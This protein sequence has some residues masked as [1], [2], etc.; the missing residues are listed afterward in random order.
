MREKIWRCLPLTVIII[1]TLLRVA[2]YFFNR[3]LTE[4]EAPLALNILGRSYGD[5]LKPLDFVQAAPVGFLWIQ[6]FAVTLLGNHELVFRLVPLVAGTASLVLFYLIGRKLLTREATAIAL[7]IFAINDNLIYFASE[8][9]QYSTDVMFAVIILLAGLWVIG[10]RYRARPLAVF[11][12]LG[13]SAVW[14][15]HPALFVSAS[16][17]GVIGVSMFYDRRSRAVPWLVLAL[18][19]AVA[20]WLANYL[21]VLAV[22]RSDARLLDFWQRS[23]VPLVPRSLSDLGLIARAIAR[24][25]KNPGGFSVYDSLIAAGACGTGLVSL[26]RK[27]TRHAFALL[28]PVLAVYLASGLRLYPFEGRLLL[29]LAP[30]IAIMTA[31]GADTVRAAIAQT[32]RTGSIAVVALVLA[33]PAGAALF[34]LAKPRAPEELRPVLA[35]LQLR[36]SPDQALYVYYAAANAFKYYGPRYGFGPDEFIPGVEAR[37]DWTGYYEDL[38]KLARTGHKKAW[39]VMSHILKGHGVDEERLFRSHLE[40]LGDITDVI[41][42]SG[43]AAY[44]CEFETIDEGRRDN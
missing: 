23:F 3:S 25:F 26:F 5:L 17:F 2:Q 1:G 9:K 41:P 20:G 18:L 4:G 36:K 31:A 33:Y 37:D 24:I 10:G 13:G 12:L 38:K 19:V 16:L 15:S 30:F 43:A 42:G 11:G 6:K 35:E 21:L 29:F 44:L 32:S 7:I 39:I 14:F 34:H 28:L 40:M 27:K 8:L 22:Q